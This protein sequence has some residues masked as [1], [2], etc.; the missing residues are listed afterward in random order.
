MTRIRTAHV[1]GGGIAGQVAAVAL[2]RAGIEPCVSEAYDTDAAGVGAFLG[3]GLNGLDALRTVGMDTAVL[4]RGFATPRM[5]LLNGS[6]RVLADVPNGGALRDGTHA[7]TIRRSDLYAALRDEA[8][9]RGIPTRH[10]KRLTAVR[11]TDSGV[12][13]EFGDGSTAEADV[14]VGADGIHS[15]VRGLLDPA[16]PGAS[17]VGFLNTGGYA[18]GVDVP[19]PPGVNH[20]C[21]GRRAFIGWV[22]AP[23]G[24]VWW[25]AN[26]P[27]PREPRPE[28]L[29]AIPAE[30][31]RA[32]LLDLFAD[33]RGPAADL[34][35]AT[36]EVFAGWTTYDL[37][38][39][40][41]WHDGRTV[42]IGD[43]AHAVSPSVGQGAAMAIEDAVVLAQCL[44]DHDDAPAALSRYE[45][46]RRAR[47]EKVRTQGR[48]NGSGK[49]V[50]PVGRAARDLVLP[51]VMRR[52][53]RDGRDPLRWMWDHH[54]D[55]ETSVTDPAPSP[56]SR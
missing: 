44:R 53:F 18:R 9:R 42:I 22:K 4:A 48:R 15:T 5:V 51:I 10:G 26:P 29:A 23:D 50:G 47:V 39:V 31:W 27:A 37:P 16:A 11:H 13:A 28:E 20:L 6:G 21:F 7:L 3:L 17:Y 46:L 40:P 33:D 38:S 12:R 1:V 25:F 19:G 2:H 14:L 36:D 54:I 34:I 35:R 49:T 52:L 32:R 56:A 30:R 43:A 8:E 24:E 45:Q 55:W 41:T